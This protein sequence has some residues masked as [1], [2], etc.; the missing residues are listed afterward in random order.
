MPSSKRRLRGSKKQGRLLLYAVPIIAVVMTAGVLGLSYLRPPQ[1]MCSDKATG[2]L[3]MDFG[4][5]LSIQIVNNEGNQTRLIVP[6][7][8]GVPSGYW[9]NHTLAGYGTNGISPICSDTPAPG[10]QYQGYSSIRV[11][12]TQIMNYTLRDFFN[13]WGQPLGRNAT[14]ATLTNGIVNARP[15][16]T[17]EMCIGNPTNTSNL[18]LGNWNV[19]VLTPNKF[20]TLVYFNHQSS[21]PG[22]IG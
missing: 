12:S 19:E 14:D 8:V 10:A 17:W 3:K 20:I 16:Y 15:N 9:A 1:I 13:I 22:C 18:T 2:S 21:Y 7:E 5:A 4:V 6:P 11:R